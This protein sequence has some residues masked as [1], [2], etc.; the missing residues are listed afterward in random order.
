MVSNPEAKRWWS[1]IF[2]DE[3]DIEHEDTGSH[4]IGNDKEAEI[5]GKRRADIWETDN[6]HWC[7][8][9]IRE[10]HGVI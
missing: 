5:E 8:K 2:V 6:H 7:L 4:F 1:Y 9:I 10:S 3:D